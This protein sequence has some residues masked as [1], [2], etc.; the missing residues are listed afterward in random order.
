[1]GR[2]VT[3][4]TPGWAVSFSYYWKAE[5]WLA[6]RKYQ[7]RKALLKAFL[8]ST[9]MEGLER[10]FSPLEVLLVY[11]RSPVCSRCV[12]ERKSLRGQKRAL[13]LPELKLQEGRG[14]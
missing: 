1:M 3:V 9:I 10:W 4:L 2:I 11:Q 13:D 14:C 5:P 6:L 12:R 7:G 8:Q